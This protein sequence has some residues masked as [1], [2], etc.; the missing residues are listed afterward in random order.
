[1]LRDVK[2]KLRA[3]VCVMSATDYASLGE[4]PDGLR[5]LL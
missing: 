3:W 1:M 2:R 5:A 4:S